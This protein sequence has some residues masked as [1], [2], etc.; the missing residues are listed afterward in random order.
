[1]ALTIKTNRMLWERAASRCALT[2]CRRELVIDRIDTDDPSL[3]GEAAHVVAERIDGPRGQSDLALEKRNKYANL[4]LLCNVHHKQVDDQVGWF[5]V[6]RLNS[7]KAEHE[8]WVRKSLSGFD[9]AKQ[10]DDE[11]WAAYIEGT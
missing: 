10:Q 6:E 8:N 3:V 1:M 9:A 4:I 2:E 11:R 7:I 5:T